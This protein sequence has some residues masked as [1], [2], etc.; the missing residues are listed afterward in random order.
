[1]Y[2]KITIIPQKHFSNVELSTIVIVST[3]FRALHNHSYYELYLLAGFRTCFS[4]QMGSITPE[5]D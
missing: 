5:K 3:I 1:M 4:Q 2:R